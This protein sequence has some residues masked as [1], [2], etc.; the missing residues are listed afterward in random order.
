[1]PGRSARPGCFCQR[2]VY[3]HQPRIPNSKRH[4]GAGTDQHRKKQSRHRILQEGLRDQS[5]APG[6]LPTSGR[7][8]R[9]GR[10]TTCLTRRC[11]LS[12]PQ[13]RWTLSIDSCYLRRRPRSRLF[14]PPRCLCSGLQA[15]LNPINGQSSS[16]SRA[17]SSQGAFKPM[18]RPSNRMEIPAIPEET[19]LNRE[20]TPV[21]TVPR[22]PPPRGVE[23]R[24]CHTIAPHRVLKTWSAP[25]HP[26]C[27][28]RKRQCI[29]CNA[30]FE[31]LE[32][33]ILP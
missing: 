5:G 16:I 11:L 30:R 18:K 17:T 25:G 20:E 10:Q 12:W 3:G 33:A 21:E 29:R 7:S 26:G 9:P 1:M 15:C 24:T 19:L 28:R 4:G 14:R 6:E 22:E 32:E 23:C 31:T 8:S 27:V 2:A 13:R